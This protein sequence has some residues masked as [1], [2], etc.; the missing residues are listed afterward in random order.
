MLQFAAGQ[1]WS[2]AVQDHTDYLTIN[3]GDPIIRLP[4]YQVNSQT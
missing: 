1:S 4:N 3:L 2:R